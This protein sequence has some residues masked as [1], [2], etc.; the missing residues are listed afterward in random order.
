MLE[1]KAQAPD[2]G[3][4]HQDIS[5]AE[6]AAAEISR[7]NLL[8]IETSRLPAATGRSRFADF[9]FFRTITALFSAVWS[10]DRAELQ[11]IPVRIRDRL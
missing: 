10:T 9:D 7:A 8:R 6:R 3:I 2:H 5:A 1:F 4:S 11:P